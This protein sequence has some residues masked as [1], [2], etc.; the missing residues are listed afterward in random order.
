MV[1]NATW[2]KILYS[3][4]TAGKKLPPAPDNKSKTAILTSLYSRETVLDFLH[5]HLEWVTLENP[6]HTQHNSTHSKAGTNT[7]ETLVDRP[8][9]A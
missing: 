8:I 5:L 7:G 9:R 1:K 6:Q 4:Y 3:A 2:S